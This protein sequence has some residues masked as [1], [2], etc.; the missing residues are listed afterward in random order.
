VPF[1][2][3]GLARGEAI[4]AGVGAPVA[5]LL[6]EVLSDQWPEVASFDM[7]ELGRNP[8]RIIAAMWDFARRHAEGPVRFISEPFWPGRP[9][10]STGPA[11]TGTGTGPAGSRSRAHRRRVSRRHEEIS[12]G[13]SASQPAPGHAAPADR[14][15][16]TRAGAPGSSA[17]IRSAIRASVAGSVTNGGIP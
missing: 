3:D 7:S 13:R 17:V 15:A 5:D 14:P 6:C 11:T 4:L 1:V 12:R 2:R 16:R 8:G 10:E 9:A